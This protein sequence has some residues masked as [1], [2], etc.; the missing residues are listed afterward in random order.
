MCVKAHKSSK[1]L[2][3]VAGSMLRSV[4]ANCGVKEHT[5]LSGEQKNSEVQRDK[6]ER[7]LGALKSA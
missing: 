1:N 3:C 4:R 2:N 7:T 6:C 5:E